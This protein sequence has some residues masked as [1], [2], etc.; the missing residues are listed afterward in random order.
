MFSGR[1]KWAVTPLQVLN[2]SLPESSG[3]KVDLA[4]RH[5]ITASY[6]PKMDHVN[7]LLM[8]RK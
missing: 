5:T 7:I 1:W 2:G 8:R 3:R 6:S 4:P